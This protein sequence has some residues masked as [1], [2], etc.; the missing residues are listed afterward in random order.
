V[1]SVSKWLGPDLRLAVLVGDERTIR[2]VAGRQA[3]GPGWVSVLNQ[4]IA[5]TLWGD[6]EVMALAD[7]AATVYAGRR[8]ALIDA[9]AEH[10]IEVEARSGFNLWIP[11]PDEDAAARALWAAG[12]AV[13][14]G[15]RHRLASGPAVRV[16]TATMRP[17][18]A[19]A[20]AATLAAASQPER[21][22]TRAA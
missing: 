22:L 8:R 13:S 4:R 20:V 12:F 19:P 5:A 2:R 11:V 10:E 14:T 3:V 9:L 18:E 15:A 7:Q 17:S 6:P 21:D 16:T 1:R